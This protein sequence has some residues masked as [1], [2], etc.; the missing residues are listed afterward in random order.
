M[1]E[2][3]KKTNNVTIDS[4]HEPPTKDSQKAG[5]FLSKKVNIGT[6]KA[7]IQGVDSNIAVENK[8]LDDRGIEQAPSKF[9]FIRLMKGFKNS[10][11]SRWHNSNKDSDNT[12]N[13]SR[14]YKKEDIVVLK[15]QPE[16]QNA[17]KNFGAIGQGN[18]GLVNLVADT[19]TH[20][21]FVEKTDDEKRNPT[22]QSNRK[23]GY[24]EILVS[25]PE[26]DNLI[27][28]NENEQL[29]AFGGVS[30]EEILFKSHEKK[31]LDK[32][33]VKHTQW[34]ILSGLK[35]L[36]K[37]G[38]A[39]NNLKLSKV[40]VNTGTGQVKLAGFEKVQPASQESQV[41][42]RSFPY[43]TPEECLKEY[44]KVASQY[45]GVSE[46]SSLRE[47]RR[48]YANKQLR[49]DSF[50]NSIIYKKIKLTKAFRCMLMLRKKAV[51]VYDKAAQVLGVGEN[52]TWNEVKERYKE[53]KKY[54]NPVNNDDPNAAQI[55]RGIKKAYKEMK[56]SQAFSYDELPYND[57]ADMNDIWASGICLYELLS[58]NKFISGVNN[59]IISES[60]GFTSWRSFA[61]SESLYNVTPR[62][63]QEKVT[64]FISSKILKL[65]ETLKN[66]KPCQFTSDELAGKE[67]YLLCSL[68][69][70]IKEKR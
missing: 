55:L 42:N 17:K 14:L 3:P 65:I 30:C 32:R 58:G 6:P 43:M 53:R 66:T 36:H 15:D 37:M 56:N 25:I 59:D 47:I 33:W 45:L 9:A 52:A 38:L 63:L 41:K 70:M 20:Q 21:F 35:H 16:N 24:S 31:P 22:N 46:N 2:P 60:Y 27:S 19:A 49:L 62:G 50:D 11:I 26:H 67:E 57:R 12:E 34:S 51:L 40:L 64:N 13:V 23:L 10:L 29:M 28:V 61:K 39:H 68:A 54:W 4:S 8:K 44:N 48:C 1:M 18:S 69:L 7:Y 5:D